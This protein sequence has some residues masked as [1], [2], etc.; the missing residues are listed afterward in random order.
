MSLK[1]NQAILFDIPIFIPVYNRTNHLTKLL[2]VLRNINP[3]RIYFS[4]DGPKNKDDKKKIDQVKLLIKNCAVSKE[5]KIKFFERN[6]GC[7]D[8]VINGLNWFFENEEEGIILEDDCIPSVSFFN[9]CKTNLEY[10]RNN[11]KIMNI[12]G[13]NLLKELYDL[14]FTKK[15]ESYFYTKSPMIW[16]WAT[17]KD[18]W[19]KIDPNL[20]DYEKVIN[21]KELI[22]KYYNDDISKKFY[23]KR[24]K[25]VKE[26]RDSSWAYIWDFCLRKNQ[27]LNITPKVNLVKNIG[28]DEMATHKTPS[29]QK[30]SNLRN[31]EMKFDCHNDTLIPNQEADFLLSSFFSKQTTFEK[32]KSFVVNFKKKLLYIVK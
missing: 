9:F 16:G 29:Y 11:K 22:K 15:N 32:F 8:A 10:H 7:K 26:N 25:E 30:L 4:C 27:G 28:F 12:G 31:N 14:D 17:W 20:E 5:M 21:D 1:N 24:L 18:R 6:Y 19:H 23:M 13:L 2:K 3:K